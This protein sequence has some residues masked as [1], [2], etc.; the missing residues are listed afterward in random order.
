MDTSKYKQLYLQ[1]AH[2]HLG[3]TEKALLE[4]EKESTPESVAVL[5]DKLF[6]HYHTIKGMSASMGYEVIAKLSH[7]QEDLLSELRDKTIPHS[8]E[9][10]A[11]LLE[12]LDMLRDLVALIEDDR[13]AKA[14][15]G[16]FVDKLKGI[17]DTALAKAASDEP[18]GSPAGNKD[19]PE[20]VSPEK[21]KRRA[22]DRRQPAA[23]GPQLRLSKLMKVDSNVFDELHTTAG[24]L[25]MELSGFKNLS[26]TLRSVEMK[27]AVHTLSKSINKLHNSILTARMLPIRDLTEGLPRIIRD[28]TSKSD[29]SVSLKI[30][31]A[32]VSL[33]RAVLENLSGPLVHIIRNAVDH[34]IEEPGQRKNKKP[35]GTI[36]IKAYGTRDIVVLEVSDDGK[37]IDIDRVKAKA[38]ERGAAAE[39]IARMSP[40]EI[41]MLVC[42]P[43][44][45]TSRTVSETS[46]RGVGMDV[47]KKDVEALGGSL[48][49]SSELGKGTTV[50]LEL[51]RTTSIIK[52]LF[53]NVADEI[54]M[55][56][57]SEIKRVVEVER[58]RLQG[59]IFRSEDGEMPIIPLGTAL[60]I[61]ENGADGTCTMLV[62]E[63]RSGRQ[64][65]IIEGT[66][67]PE[68]TKHIAIQVD[69]F[70][71]E[72]DAYIKPLLPPISSL[73]GVLG[74]TITAEGRPVFLVDI[75]QIISAASLA[76]GD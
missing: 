54:L 45:S 44:L 5:I 53:V 52:V 11:A 33:D 67:P 34:G 57:L 23:T 48:T 59:D 20:P 32:E 75:P 72:T 7:A 16:P 50:T 19:A 29:K 30:E 3:G 8:P 6:R 22:E 66:T 60:G 26:Q 43:G 25:F 35:E 68:E 36:K 49:L 58:A 39:E 69:N 65:T 27:D 28:I 41:L 15:I 21:Q 13:P 47:V 31:G 76:T 1:E 18:A 9:I 38:I 14:E 2:E 64:G 10:G 17:K 24:D 46:G 63:D 71:M 37:G 56:P 51:P 62:V 61:P 73:K 55:L 12:G 70:G 40:H 42:N 74:I 4:L